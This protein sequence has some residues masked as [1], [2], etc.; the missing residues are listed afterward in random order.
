MNLIKSKKRVVDH[1]EVFTPPW[2]V[3]AM[4][5]LV[6]GESQRINS[7]FLEPACGSGHFMVAILARKLATVQATYAKSPQDRRYFAL[8]G[9]MSIY[10]IELLLDNV[11]EC[12]QVMLERFAQFMGIDSDDVLYRAASSVVHAN[13]VHGDALTMKTS[14]GQAIAFAE[15]A[16]LGKGRYKR[17]DFRLDTLT[18]SSTFQAEGSLFA[19]L[20]KHEL[21]MPVRDYPPMSVRD[22][23]GQGSVDDDSPEQATVATQEA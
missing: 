13:I 11:N 17:R 22:L 8:L 12:R 15:W 5:D 21:F 3:E 10:G 9:L 4:L 1:G 19:G 14:T 2:M 16:Y 18:G 6:K 20:G 7:R 23:A